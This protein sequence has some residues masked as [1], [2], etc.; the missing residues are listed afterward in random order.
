MVVWR[1]DILGPCSRYERRPHISRQ[2][3]GFEEY[4]DL[5]LHLANETDLQ[6]CTLS[7][8]RCSIHPKG[9]LDGGLM[10]TIEVPGFGRNL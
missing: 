3:L 6:A 5:I 2:Y 9:K 8:I 1:P 10:H 7:W 4:V